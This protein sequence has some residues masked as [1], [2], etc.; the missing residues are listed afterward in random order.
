MGRPKMKNFVCF[1]LGYSDLD[2]LA[3]EMDLT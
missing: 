2:C 1:S 3:K